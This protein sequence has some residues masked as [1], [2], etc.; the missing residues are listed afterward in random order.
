[1]MDCW[2]DGLIYYLVDELLEYGIDRQWFGVLAAS[3][4]DG[5]L[6]LYINLL[7]D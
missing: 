2:I 4:V 7:M 5:F 6:D 1:M 3:W